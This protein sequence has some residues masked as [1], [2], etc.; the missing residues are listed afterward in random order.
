ML[1][2]DRGK[3]LG[4]IWAMSEISAKDRLYALY[5]VS[6]ALPPRQTGPS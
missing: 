1:D 3:K 4:L 5:R 2:E 6:D